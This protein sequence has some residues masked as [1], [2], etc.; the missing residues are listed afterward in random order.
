MEVEEE[1]DLQKSQLRQREEG[2][3][4]LYFVDCHGNG[5]C[6]LKACAYCICLDTANNPK[7][8]KP[9][10]YGGGPLKTTF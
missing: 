6:E 3:T 8:K 7:R 2:A 4:D 5:V 9:G 1:P 10:V